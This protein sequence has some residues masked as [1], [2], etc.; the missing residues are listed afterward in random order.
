MYIGEHTT[1]LDEKGRLNVPKEFRMLMDAQ[2]HKVWVATR[3]FNNF[4]QLYEKS[5]WD[6]QFLPKLPPSDPMNPNNQK[7]RRFFL[8]SAS[9]VERDSAGRLTLPATLRGWAGLDG[10]S[11]EA[12]LVGMETHL[13]LWSRDHWNQFHVDEAANIEAMALAY[14]ADRSQAHAPTQGA[15]Q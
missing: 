2:H 7:V 10:E 9:F 13:E 11:R 5:I 15:E 4:I 14:S 8:G 3:G 1:T 12:V 6:N